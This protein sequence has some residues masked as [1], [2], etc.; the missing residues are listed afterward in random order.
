MELTRILKP[1][2]TE[3]AKA[4]RRQHGDRGGCKFSDKLL[5][6]SASPCSH[7]ISTVTKD[8]LIA[9]IYE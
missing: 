3:H 9:I 6:I 1:T 4:Y 8:N 5:L 2:R 7:T